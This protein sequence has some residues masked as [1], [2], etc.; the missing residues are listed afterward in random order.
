ML[1]NAIETGAGDRVAL[2]LHGMMG[3]SESW[4][5]IAPVL[6]RGGYRVIAVDLPGHGLS[7][8]DATCSIASV[9]GDV[10]ETVRSVAP[11]API[12][13][14]GHSY[15]GTVLA[16][17]AERMPIERA[18]YVDTACAFEGGEDQ[19]ALA[20]QYEADRRRRADPGWLRSSR[21]FYSETDAVV[22]ARA[23]DRF[24]PM[25]AASISAGASV[26]GIPA[27]GSILVR[28][29]PSNFVTDVDVQRLQERGVD[30][31]S[32]PDAAHTIWYSHF[33]EFCAALPELFG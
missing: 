29:E 22:E 18:V 25:T 10:V 33:D 28:A 21:P 27:R 20:A 30:V 8:R 19:H 15:G 7:P 3:S 1:L 11:G 12:D 23:A 24:D 9:A 14:I 26:E 32:I 16:A 17:A 13:A 6:E 5:R 2:L 31:R 4:W